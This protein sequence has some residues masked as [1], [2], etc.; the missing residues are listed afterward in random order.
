MDHS[1][2]QRLGL[3]VWLIGRDCKAYFWSPSAPI[4]ESMSASP[5]LA[6]SRPRNSINVEALVAPACDRVT[7]LETSLYRSPSFFLTELGVYCC[8]YR[9]GGRVCGWGEERRGRSKGGGEV[10]FIRLVTD[11]TYSIRHKSSYPPNLSFKQII[12]GGDA[13]AVSLLSRGLR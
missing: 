9:Q 6:A 13:S 11:T 4:N 12:L 1:Q 3:I 5:N 10:G 8:R 2:L 7:A